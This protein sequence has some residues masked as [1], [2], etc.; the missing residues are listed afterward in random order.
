MELVHA[1][2]RSDDVG[3]VVATEDHDEQLGV[4]EVRQRVALTVN[5]R[6]F[7]SGGGL[8]DL[9]RKGHLRVP[10]LAGANPLSP[11]GLYCPRSALSH[12]STNFT[13]GTELHESRPAAAGIREQGSGR[14]TGNRYHT[15]TYG[16]KR[17][18]LRPV[19]TSEGRPIFPPGAD[20]PQPRRHRRPE[21]D[22]TNPFSNLRKIKKIGKPA[23]SPGPP[24]IGSR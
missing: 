19:G 24:G 6:Q 18:L 14:P 8:S 15:K 5:A 12:C 11:G 22:K 3:A 23:A 4:G 9:K 20:S 13:N 21:N 16:A 1:V 2:F 7:E 10:F 17:T